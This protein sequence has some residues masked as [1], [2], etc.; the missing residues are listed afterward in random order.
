M[1]SCVITGW[2]RIQSE[3]T[4]VDIIR[5]IKQD[6]ETYCVDQDELKWESIWEYI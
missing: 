4:I 2:C 1:N 5:N 3:D 6:Y